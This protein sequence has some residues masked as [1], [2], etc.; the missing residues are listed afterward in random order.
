[1]QVF[2]LKAARSDTHKFG[3][4]RNAGTVPLGANVFGRLM[5]SSP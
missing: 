1:M 5:T 4:A 2:G 3:A